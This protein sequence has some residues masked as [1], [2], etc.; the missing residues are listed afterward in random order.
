MGFWAIF[1]TGSRMV[2]GILFEA[3]MG[4]QV[5]KKKGYVPAEKFK[6]LPKTI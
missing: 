6:K 5:F 4:I 1:F 3:R 2:R